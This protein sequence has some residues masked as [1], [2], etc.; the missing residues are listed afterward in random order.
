[1]GAVVAAIGS[2]VSSVVAPSDNEDVN[3][4]RKAELIVGAAMT[5][6]AGYEALTAA[7]AVAATGVEGA[8]LDT[9]TT[10]AANVEV[11]TNAAGTFSASEF[12]ASTSQLGS[13]VAGMTGGDVS[14]AYAGSLAGDAATSSTV[15]G[16]ATEAGAYATAADA[17]LTGSSVTIGDVYNAAKQGYQAV[18]TVR[19]VSQAIAPRV[20]SNASAIGVRTPAQQFA[21][22]APAYATTAAALTGAQQKAFGIA[23]PIAP[24][25][26][27]QAQ[28]PSSWML[29]VMVL[30]I[31]AFAYKEMPHG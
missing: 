21:W 29:P 10:L 24:A 30:A 20:A 31:L 13:G 9:G 2:V 17:T 7:D 25:Q 4:L 23:D 26:L 6:Y 22:S 16:G 19:Q 15:I 5:G 28:K 12:G 18:S 8:T 1:M 14:T 11:S 3:R 27:A